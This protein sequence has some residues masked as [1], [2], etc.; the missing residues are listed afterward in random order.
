MRVLAILAALASSVVGAASDVDVLHIDLGRLITVAAPRREQFAVNVPHQIRPGLL[1]SWSDNGDDLVWHY[2][3]QVPSA[4]SMA[5]HAPHVRLPAG[6]KLIVSGGGERH[7]YDAKS[8]RQYRLWSHLLPGDTIAFELTVPSTRID[9]FELEIASL[10]VGYRALQPGVRNHP[11]YDEWRRKL[12]REAAPSGGLLIAS[13]ELLSEACAENYLCHVD[14]VP[15]DSAAATTAIVIRN[16]FLCTG[17]LINDV[18]RSETPYVLVARHCQ[19][20]VGPGGDPMAAADSRFYWNATDPCGSPLSSIFSSH[21]NSQFGA[22]TMVEQEDLW[23]VRLN[24]QPPTDVAARAGW[25]ATGGTFVGGFSTHHAVGRSLQFAGWHAAPHLATFNTPWYQSIVWRTIN[26]LGNVGHGASG[27]ALFDPAGRTVGVLSRGTFAANSTDDYGVCPVF[28]LQPPTATFWSGEFVALGPIWNST[29]DQSSTTNPRTLRSV[30]DPLD[31]GMLVVDSIP[32]SPPVRIDLDS[33]PPF[34]QMLIGN[35][36]TLTWTTVNAASCEASGGGPAGAWSGTLPT[37]GSRS[38]TE[39]DVGTYTYILTCTNP[40]RSQSQQLTRVWVEPDAH[41]SL[42]FVPDSP[43]AVGMDVSLTWDSNVGP[44]DATGG[45][46]GDGWAGSKPTSG[47]LLI[48]S[49]TP[50][51]VTYAMTCG[52]A[53]RIAS[54]SEMINWQPIRAFISTNEPQV[55]AIR[56]GQRPTLRY[57]AAAAS[58]MGTGGSPGD[59]W[60][61]PRE[62]EGQYQFT[63]T[64]AGTF[65]YGFECVSGPNFASDEVTLTWTDGPP[66]AT[67]NATPIRAILGPNGGRTEPIDFTWISNVKPCRLDFVGPRSGIKSLGLDWAGSRFDRRDLPGQYTYTLSCGS[68][69][70][71][72]VTSVDVEWYWPAAMVDLQFSL[73]PGQPPIYGSDGANLNWESNISPCIATGGAPGDG[74]AGLKSARSS[75]TVRPPQ[76]GSYTYV[77]TCGPDG[78]QDSDELTLQFDP[79]PAPIFEQFGVSPLSPMTGEVATLG[80]HQRYATSCVA[81]GGYPGDGWAGPK[82]PSGNANV[83]SPVPGILIYRLTCSNN[84]GSTSTELAVQWTGAVL[85]FAT[86]SA[87]PATVIVGETVT[88][89]WTSERATSCTASGGMTGDG[90]AG[91]RSP[92]G[93]QAIQMTALGSVQYA[94]VCGSSRFIAVA[95]RVNAAPTPIVNISVI[96]DSIPLGDTAVI[97]WNVAGSTRCEATGGTPDFGNMFPWQGVLPPSGTR[98]VRPQN[99]GSWNYFLTCT[100]PGTL[101]QGVVQLAVTDPLNPLTTF[102]ID[103]RVVT[104]GGVYNVSWDVIGA[105]ICV[106]SGGVSGDGW[107]GVLPHSGLRSITATVVGTH[108]YGLECASGTGLTSAQQNVT[109]NARPPPSSSGGGGGS[110]DLFALAILGALGLRPRN[111]LVSRPLTA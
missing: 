42:R 43:W 69:A 20:G 81:S 19:G 55:S 73:A 72:V 104:V 110:I 58:C 49:D 83:V 95:V 103:P 54:A 10:Q 99:R 91:T 89:I 14:E 35:L 64:V 62:R 2:S 97:N 67:L 36:L 44:C 51:V 11:S 106:A 76:P 6:A 96:P 22:V 107:T 40:I 93:S 7:V 86:L 77:L 53:P 16:M 92:S 80:W 108:N 46:P 33:S 24:D 101:A 66:A 59:G 109:I 84:A 52:V 32:P 111:W 31:T 13:S 75:G 30:L 12:Q 34:G 85:A 47:S 79:P 63:A 88:I 8:I 26:A 102:S 50:D 29:A 90:W 3:I 15:T 21:T 9:Q 17:T 37:S 68:G 1:G 18:P 82:N 105:T 39:T 98:T 38:F 5:F 41:V 65:V 94:I 70:D 71:S 57:V 4:V 78:N 56:I 28:P 25:D 60:A 74:W 27:G 45:L 61:G 87:Q 23:L 100:A 48:R